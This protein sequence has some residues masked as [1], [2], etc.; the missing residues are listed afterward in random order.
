MKCISELNTEEQ[1]ILHLKFLGDYHSD[2]AL[3]AARILQQR[4]REQGVRTRL[5]YRYSQRQIAEL[6]KTNHRNIGRKLQV[7]YDEL[8]DVF[9]QNKLLSAQV[10]PLSERRHA[11]NVK[12]A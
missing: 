8:E 7:I 2:Q 10:I 4:L 11:K 1:V 5:S 12:G 6:L 9:L 3:S